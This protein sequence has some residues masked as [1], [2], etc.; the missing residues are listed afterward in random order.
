MRYAA[1]Y[2]NNGFRPD[3]QIDGFLISADIYRVEIIL[4]DLFISFYHKC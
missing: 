4:T 2:I 1:V 3:Q